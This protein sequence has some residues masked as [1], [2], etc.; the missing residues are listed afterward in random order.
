MFSRLLDLIIHEVVKLHVNFLCG[1]FELKLY[2]NLSHH[3]QLGVYNSDR[4][5]F[6][7]FL[8]MILASLVVAKNCLSFSLA[9]H[10]IMYALV[11]F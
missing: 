1:D 2:A 3:R 8:I 4:S 10:S 9:S 11:R 7:V 6:V 5:N